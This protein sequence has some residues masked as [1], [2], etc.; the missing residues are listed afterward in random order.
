VLGELDLP[1]ASLFAGRYRIVRRIAAGG[2]GAVFEVVHT[3]TQ[4]RRALKIML[5]ELLANSQ[6]RE[7]FQLEARVTANVESEHIVD[8]FDA[9]IDDSTGMPFLVMELL[10]G[11]DLGRILETEGPL[12]PER[13]VTYLRQIAGALDKT[14]AAGIVHRDLKPENLFLTHREDGTP[15]VK[16]LDFG[17]SKVV[18][19][20]PQ[21]ARV[22]RGIGTPLYMAPEQA[23]AHTVGPATDLYAL[24]LI[25]YTLL[26][27]KAYW[28]PEVSQFESAIAFVIHT[29]K[30]ATGSAVRR[31]VDAGQ[32]LPD[33]FDAWFRRATAIEPSERFATAAECVDEL[34]LV[35]A[36]KTAPGTE[37][38]RQGTLAGAATRGSSLRRFGLVAVGLAG[39]AAAGAFA[40]RSR[41]VSSAGPDA[42]RSSAPAAAPDPESVPPTPPAPAAAPATATTPSVSVASVSSAAL[43]LSAAAAPVK[44]APPKRPSSVTKAA[45]AKAPAGAATG[46]SSKYTRD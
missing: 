26:V 12:A 19:D 22:T 4:R 30:G 44:P 43:A 6:L 17:I 37:L 13:A 20:A 41:P 31:A 8:V 29:S 7:R 27:G 45:P 38:D 14:H 32:T 16:I 33:T 15:R 11:Q 21:A 25:A 2:M 10:N 39:A 34:G 23:L 35:F 5:P 36:A 18:S 9:G 3:E 40:L 1:Q 42:I 24:A 46:R 28:E